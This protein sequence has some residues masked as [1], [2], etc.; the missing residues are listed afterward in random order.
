MF[1]IVSIRFFQFKSQFQ[2]RETDC[3]SMRQFNSPG[4]VAIKD[5]KFTTQNCYS[6]FCEKTKE[7]ET[8]NQIE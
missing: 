6:S 1:V 2:Q 7:K 8:L 5:G 4:A 3:V